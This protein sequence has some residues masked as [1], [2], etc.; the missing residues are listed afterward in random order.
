MI[1][2]LNLKKGVLCMKKVNLISILLAGLVG[3]VGCSVKNPDDINK[4]L[5]KKIQEDNKKNQDLQNTLNLLKKS[6]EQGGQPGNVK[7]SGVIVKDNSK[8]DIRISLFS[9][10]GVGKDGTEPVVG[11]K[12]KPAMSSKI[13]KLDISNL[14]EDKSLVTVG[15]NEKLTDDFAKERALE[16]QKIPQPLTKDVMTIQAK[17]VVLC[18]KLDDVKFPYLTIS[19]DELILNSVDYIQSSFGG[20]TNLNTNKLVLMGKNQI[21]SKGVDTAMTVPMAPSIELNVVKEISSDEE[22]QLLIIAIGSNY[23]ADEK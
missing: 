5:D 18:G 22:G 3:L 14:V 10:S 15:C 11:D 12:F 16:V 1:E 2:I 7:I 17:T 9:K 8:I 6:T 23:K 21:Q 20:F 13:E 19:A 4:D